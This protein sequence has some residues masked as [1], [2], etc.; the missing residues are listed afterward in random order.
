MPNPKICNKIADPAARRRCLEYQGEFKQPASPARPRPV[1]RPR[2]GRG[3]N[4]LQRLTGGS[5]GRPS[6]GGFGY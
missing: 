3:G 6:G 2:A 4:A 5:S 1:Q